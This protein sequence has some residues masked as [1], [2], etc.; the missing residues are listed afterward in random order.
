LPDQPESSSFRNLNDGGWSG[1]GP[2]GGAVTPAVALEAP[3]PDLEARAATGR[4]QAGPGF[5]LGLAC[6]ALPVTPSRRAFKSASWPRTRSGRPGSDRHGWCTGRWSSQRASS[7]CR[8]PRRTRPGGHGHS[9]SDA[10]ADFNFKFRVKLHA[11]PSRGGGHDDH[12]ESCHL[13]LELQVASET[14]GTIRVV[15]RAE[16]DR[17]G[18][19]E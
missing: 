11:P 13:E 17:K 2:A 4:S 3:Q 10:A 19:P 14:P 5:K 16:S 12:H 8:R 7:T 18:D 1:P 6:L 9:S 15:L